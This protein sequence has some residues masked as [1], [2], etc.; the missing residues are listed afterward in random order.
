MSSLS[1]GRLSRNPGWPASAACRAVVP[2]L[3]ATAAFAAAWY[4]V[5][6]ADRDPQ[7]K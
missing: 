3:G 4:V 2:A 6:L 5:A 7:G 1:V